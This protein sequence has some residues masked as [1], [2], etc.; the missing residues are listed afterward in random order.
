[1]DFSALSDVFFDDQDANLF[2]VADARLRADALQQSILPRL[3]LVMNTAIALIR[4]VYDVEALDDSIVSVLPNF[5]KK[6]SNYM[7]HM[8]ESA[9]V[10]LGGRRR[11][12]WPG[13]SRRDGKPVQILPFRF[14]FAL[15]ANGVFLILENGWLKGLDDR[16]FGSML[17]FHVDFERDVVPLCFASEIVPVFVRDLLPISPLSDKYEYCISHRIWQYGFFG[18]VRRFPVAQDGLASLVLDYVRFFPVYDSYIQMAKGNACRLNALV[19]RLNRWS[20]DGLADEAEE[21]ADDSDPDRRA[22]AVAR[23]AAAAETKVRVMPAIR[24]QVFQK[25]G[26]RCVACGRGSQNEIILHVDHIVPRSRGGSDALDN[27][28]T[29]C[30]VCNIGKSNHDSTDLRKI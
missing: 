29:L 22:V 4:E 16:S 30:S 14:A 9:F 6:R 5:R 23:A 1:M 19:G 17:R 24:W 3:R 15:D 10:G 20:G 26:W 11:A 8:Y 27:Y 18:R 7:E 28:Q 12:M 21:E 25:D 2:L 13:F